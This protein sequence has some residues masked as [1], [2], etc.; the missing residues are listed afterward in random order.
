MKLSEEKRLETR[1]RHFIMGL[2]CLILLCIV[3]SVAEFHT[4]PKSRYDYARCKG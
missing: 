2:A 1:Q 3:V 4:A